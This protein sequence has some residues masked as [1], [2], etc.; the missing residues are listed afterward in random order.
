MYRGNVFKIHESAGII[1]ST[2]ETNR[3]QKESSMFFLIG[4]TLQPRRG[5]RAESNT[6]D[7]E[8]GDKLFNSKVSPCVE[9]CHREV[10]SREP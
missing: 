5:G 7:E 2:E 6:L 9:S 1:T 3:R 4:N 8:S 10:K